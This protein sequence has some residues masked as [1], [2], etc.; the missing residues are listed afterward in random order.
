M[1][2]YAHSDV[3]WSTVNQQI[4]NLILRKKPRRILEV[5]AG[6]NPLFD[7]DFVRKHQIEYTLLDIS[8]TELQ[9]APE[10]YHKV[11]ADIVTEPHLITGKYDLVFSRMLAEHVADGERF[12]K[13]VFAVLS[14]GG[15]AFHYFPTLYS[16][17][18]VVNKL[19]PEALAESVLHILQNDRHKSG[20]L[21][22]FPA[23]YSWCRGPSAQQIRR[24]E[25][26]GY[27]VEEYGG[28]FGNEGYY[29]KIPLARKL[30]RMISNFLIDHPVPALTAFATVMLERP[31]T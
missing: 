18:F 24:L 25:S 29:T 4:E 14:P 5:G 10:G 8:E 3:A 17:P 12:H 15:T 21:G 30:N 2:R 7:V 1:I 31:A 28:Y 23:Y 22:K 13:N 6:A 19:M 20:K 9:K 26:L 16:V 27:R 11:R